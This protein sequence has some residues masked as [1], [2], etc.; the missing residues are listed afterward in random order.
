MKK[1]LAMI[2]LG[3]FSSTAMS[4]MY[5][6]Q[7]IGS[8]IVLGG[9]GN[10]HALSTASGNPASSYLMA[11]LQGFRVGFVGPL[12]IAVEGGGVNGINDKIDDLT[13]ILENDFVSTLDDFVTA[14]AAE[15][16][17]VASGGGTAQD[18]EA[19]MDA[20]I[21]ANI[22]ATVDS[23]E[24]S[25]GDA[26]G[27]VAAIAEPIYAKFATT[28]QAPFAPI[29]YKTRRRSVFTL[30]ASASI[31]G[32]AAIL[33]DDITIT[34][35][36]DLRTV[37]NYTDLESGVSNLDDIDTD[38][39]SYIQRASDYR[40]SL[41]YSEMLSRTPTEAILVGGRI[42]FH[43]LALGQ[44][45]TVLEGGDDPSVSYGDFFISRDNTAHGF[46]LDLGAMLVG[47]NYQ[48][49]MM[50]ANV[51]EPTFD[52]EE[53]GN[54]TGL[55]AD[56]L[57]NCNAA[58]SFASAGKIS[59]NE[60]YKMEAQV[61]VDAAIKS[62]DQHFSLAASYDLNPIKDPL[63][64][65]YQWSVVSLSLFSDYILIPGIRAGIRKNLVGNELTYYTVGATL[66]RRLEI[67]LA[68][69]PENDAGN[70][71]LF[72]SMGYSFVF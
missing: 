56:D 29:I 20:Y 71:G 47:R 63:G 8:S 65:E 28:L 19:A 57:V 54:C 46:S 53:I 25:L 36:N 64:D 70:S 66:S 15:G 14:T 23:L 67:D 38:T 5:L 42:N 16:S 26:S 48:L 41:G 51:N 24:T 40:F 60:T 9:Y 34:G 3:V 13:T 17:A 11:N 32:R 18:A 44:K 72:F 68:Y 61:T 35:L 27:S 59:L 62:K 49:G 12:G 50:V 43:K 10:R 2:G 7:P 22:D 39:A 30:D 21:E 31:V 58:V 52:Y 55:T 69:A 6:Y 45:I 4:S 37:A 1:Y 33:A